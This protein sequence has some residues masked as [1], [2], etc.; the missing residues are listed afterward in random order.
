[1]SSWTLNEMSPKS[2][3]CQRRDFGGKM[4][5]SRVILFFVK[6]CPLLKCLMTLHDQLLK[7][8][9]KYTQVMVL[10]NNLFWKCL[11]LNVLYYGICSFISFTVLFVYPF[12]VLSFKTSVIVNAKLKHLNMFLKKQTELQTPLML[13]FIIGLSPGLWHCESWD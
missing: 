10:Y 4:Y 13:L 9:Y 11:K 12:C 3:C 2:L 6:E 5:C 8:I 1:M 7:A